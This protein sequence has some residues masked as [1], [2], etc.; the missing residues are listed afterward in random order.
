MGLQFVHVGRPRSDSRHLSSAKRYALQIDET[1]Q[2]TPSP[3]T[4]KLQNRQEAQNVVQCIVQR[5][6]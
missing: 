2:S 3:G 5:G 1:D 4:R 6:R